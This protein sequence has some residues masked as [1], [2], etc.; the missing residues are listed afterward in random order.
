MDDVAPRQRHNVRPVHDPPPLEGPP[1]TDGHVLVPPLHD[2]HAPVVRQFGHCLVVDA[3]DRAA[4]EAEVARDI[5]YTPR[6]VELGCG[7]RDDVTSEHGPPIGLDVGYGTELALVNAARLVD[8]AGL[9]RKGEGHSAILEELGGD[10]PSVLARAKDE[11]ALPHE[12]LV[13]LLQH[14]LGEEDRGMPRYVRIFL[15]H[16][17]HAGARALH[18]DSLVLSKEV[19]HLLLPHAH[20]HRGVVHVRPHVLDE[21]CHVALA[22]PLHLRLALVE[23]VEVATPHRAAHVV[24]RERIREDVVESKSLD[25][26][27]VDVRTQVERPLV[28]P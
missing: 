17:W 10:G 28:R 15:C 19:P 14:F 24:P 22:E 26:P 20:P 27:A 12:G 13:L 18:V 5:E 7:A 9:V 23:R 8:V 11:A 1:R 4:G 16:E 6:L 2:P 25:Q 21:L 3:L